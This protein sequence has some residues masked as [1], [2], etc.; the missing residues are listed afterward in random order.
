MKLD[1]KRHNSGWFW[2]LIG[3]FA[4]VLFIWWVSGN[5]APAAPGSEGTTTAQQAVTGSKGAP[6]K[7]VAG[8]DIVS[9]A[10]G[11]SNGSTFSSWL[12]STGVASELS[13]KGT[14]TLFLPTNASIAQLPA[15]TFKNLSAAGQKRF[16]ENHIISGKV[17]DVNAQVSSTIWT[18]SGDPLNFTRRDGQPTLVGSSVIVAQYKASNGVVYVI[19]GVLI[20]PQKLQ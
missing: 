11:I 5:Q 4:V 12:K 6:S 18:L 16:V 3:I 9:V 10:A 20:P 15:G 1:T 14:Y 19:S 13:A 8:T 17:I 7:T 2:P